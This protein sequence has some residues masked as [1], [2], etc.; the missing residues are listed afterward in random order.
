MEN[1]IGKL[2]P[3]FLWTNFLN[4]C[5]IP[6]PSK[7]ELQV[8][9]FVKK[10]AEN[11]TLKYKVDETGNVVIQKPASAG[12][13]KKIPVVIQA[14]LDMVPQKNTATI[15]DFEKDPIQAYID[16]EWVR[17]RGTT[18]GADNGIGVAAALAI[19]QDKTLLHGPLEVLLTVDEETGM[20]GA[21]GLKPGFLS[22]KIL[23]NTDNE[24]E[25]ELCVGC[26]GG[27][28][29]TAIL[30]FRKEQIKENGSVYK[31][32]LTGLKGGHSG[33]DIHLGRGNA[34]K[35]MIRLLWILTR[36]YGIK[37]S[38]YEGG[39]LR[40]AIPREAFATVIISKDKE[41]LFLEDIKDFTEII[42]KEFFPVEDNIKIAAETTAIPEYVIDSDSQDRFLNAVYAVPN[43][44]MRMITEMNGVVETSTNLS[45]IKTLNQEIEINFLLRSSVD[46]AKTD[47]CNMIQSVFELA[48]AKTEHDGSYPGW[49][50]DFNSGILTKM[51]QIYKNK[52]GTEA[53]V[54]V[55]HA[56]L[57]CGIIG[58]I[59]PG[60]DLI[61][62]G[63]T[64]V[65]PHS[66]D[67]KVEINS[68]GKF[69]DFLTETLR[70]IPEA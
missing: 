10:F 29:T 12:M 61:S 52:F 56:G 45:I 13:E 54:K 69:W 51:K 30:P 3:S 48:G 4:L 64:I 36:K 33:V 37:L 65:H 5:S 39:T 58:D 1:N 62:F 34:N 21:F 26:A 63:P 60:M 57:E 17:A 19:L 7:K 8:I 6:R 40:N 43:G 59:Y 67:E 22:G 15:H 47:L 23:L 24:D 41:K 38:V 14:H 11:L 18:L 53:S 66:P 35:I 50:P 16:G 2:Y 31:I 44:V 49:K 55:I 46:S 25:G 9:A 28:N 32:S 68:V 70:H 27:I 42:K 20:S